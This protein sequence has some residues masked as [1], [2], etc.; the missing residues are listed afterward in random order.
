[1]AISAVTIGRPAADRA[2]TAFAMWQAGALSYAALDEQSVRAANWFRSVGLGVGDHIAFMMEN[3]GEIMVL[4]WAAQRAGLIYTPIPTHLM[5]DEAGYIAADSDAR[6]V[7]CS[8]RTLGMWQ[9]LRSGLPKLEVLATVDAP[10]TAVPALA[11]ALAGQPLSP[12]ADEFE[13]FAM[14]YS[15]GTTGRPKGIRRPLSGARFGEDK[16]SAIYRDYHGMD[17]DTVYLSPA[18]LYHAAPVRAVMAVQRLGGTVIALERFD[19]ETLLAA[20]D[21]HRVTHVQ[22]VPTMM[23]RILDL[24]VAVRQRYDLSSLVRVI[25]AA[26]PCPVDLKREAIDVFGPIVSEYYGGTEGVGMTYITAREWLDHPGSVG[27]AVLGQTHIVGDDGQDCAPGQAGA[28]YFAGGPAFAYHK[29]PAKTAEVTDRHGRVTLG[30]VGYLDDQGY[31]Y[32]VDR[33]AF[34]INSGGVNI[35]PVEVEDVLRSHPDVVDVAVI[36]VPDRDL[37]EVVK[38]VVECRS[39]PDD[40]DGLERDLIAFCRARI[41]RVKCPKSVDFVDQLPRS[42]MGKLMKSDLKRRYWPA[43]GSAATGGDS[44]NT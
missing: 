28:V 13:G 22:L 38:A 44:G 41:S 31:L 11:Q 33:R 4:A 10:D 32:L 15:S 17:F 26:A 9:G 5:S 29:D 14:L 20:I 34:V 18:P 37:G 21:H 24:P 43:A 16:L 30:D 36:G 25:H 19:A 7:V 23:R 42:D 6:L 27:R 35:Y 3:R 39:Q 1:M 40:P 2:K 12:T 8:A